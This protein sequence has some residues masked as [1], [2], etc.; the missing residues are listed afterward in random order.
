MRDRPVY[1]LLVDNC[2]MIRLGT[3]VFILQRITAQT[4][5]GKVSVNYTRSITQQQIVSPHPMV[6]AHDKRQTSDCRLNFLQN[7][8]R[9]RARNIFIIWESEACM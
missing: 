6:F 1:L 7:C 4:Q 8:V 9:T 2:S 3:K 5:W